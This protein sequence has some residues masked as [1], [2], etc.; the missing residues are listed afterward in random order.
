MKKYFEALQNL[1]KARRSAGQTNQH[2]ADIAGCTQQHI[3][4][5]LNRNPEL[6]GKVKLETLLRLFPSFFA[7]CLEPRTGTPLTAEEVKLILDYRASSPEGRELVRG[8]AANAAAS[9]RG[10]KSSVG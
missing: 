8:L 1:L 5:L 9:A 6:F 7:P 2:I 4:R 10:E 3:N